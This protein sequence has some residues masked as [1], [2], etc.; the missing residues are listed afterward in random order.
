M[1]L[2]NFEL[3]NIEYM[4]HYLAYTPNIDMPIYLVSNVIFRFKSFNLLKWYSCWFWLVE[5]HSIKRSK[6]LMIK[7]QIPDLRV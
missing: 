7:I 5:L 4:N 1:I 6:I 2:I 3:T